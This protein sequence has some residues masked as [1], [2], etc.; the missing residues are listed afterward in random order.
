MPTNTTTTDRRC[1][2]I[3]TA[4][5]VL[6]DDLLRL[7][8]AGSAEVRVAN[9]AVAAR[10]GWAAAP[11]VLL[12]A[13]AVEE[14]VRARLPARAAVMLITRADQEVPPWRFAEALRVEQVVVLPQAETWL[15][16]R[17]ADHALGSPTRGRVVAVLGGRG[18][19]GASVLAAALAV[20]GRRREL[21]TMLIDADPFGGGVDLVLGWETMQG[22]RWPDLVDA[23][24]LVSPP[25]VMSAF[26]GEGQQKPEAAEVTRLRREVARLKM[27]RDILKKAAAYFAKESM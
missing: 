19:A 11:F 17:F 21:D 27:E 4:D 16:D 24:G 20:T 9:D 5:S 12:G 15:V 10:A 1:P 26:P 23:S 25:P 8:A 14:V 18:G 2:L 6:L 7:A 3:V 13:D 22:L